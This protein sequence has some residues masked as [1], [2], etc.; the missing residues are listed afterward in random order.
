[1]AGTQRLSQRISEDGIALIVRVADAASAS[2]AE[3]EGAKAVAVDTDI[4]GIREATSLPVVWTGGTDDVPV[5]VDAVLV[6][7]HDRPEEFAPPP[8]LE[9]VICVHDDEDLEEALDELDPDLLVIAPKDADDGPHDGALEM[10][11]DVPAGK[12]VIADSD[13]GSRDEV[14]ALERAGFD[15]VI[16]SAGSIVDL[17]G[18]IIPDDPV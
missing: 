13:P 3:A 8:G 7:M 5:E 11:P 16:V 15:A 14:V 4:P 12:L 1:M 2:T 9:L 10:L 17:V 18:D 6:H